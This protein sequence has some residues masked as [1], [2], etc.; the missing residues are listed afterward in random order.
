[1]IAGRQMSDKV[2]IAGPRKCVWVLGSA[3]QELASWQPAGRLDEQPLE[4]S[5]PIARESPQIGKVAFE[6]VALRRRVMDRRID[7]TVN[8]HDSLGAQPCG[9]IV[10]R[11]PAGIAKHYIEVV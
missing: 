1:M 4:R 3:H 9:E 11:P 5:L 2:N 10:E 6:L 8:R 7:T